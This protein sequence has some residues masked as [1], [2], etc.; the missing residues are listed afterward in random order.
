MNHVEL[1]DVPPWFS[2]VP[3]HVTQFLV[4]PG[5]TPPLVSTFHIRR[6]RPTA[7]QDD[8]SPPLKAIK[9]RS[10]LQRPEI[11]HHF[12]SESVQVNWVTCDP[13]HCSL[14]CFRRLRGG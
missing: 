3:Q 13:I 2:E 7:S 9:Q 4:N 10:S 1:L 5:E 6:S 11:A 12:P 14:C 8:F